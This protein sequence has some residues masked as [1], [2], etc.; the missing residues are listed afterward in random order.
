[1]KPSNASPHNP[2]NRFR[3]YKGGPQLLGP[4]ALGAPGCPRRGSLGGV[5]ERKPRWGRYSYD[6]ANGNS[7]KN[8]FK[9]WISGASPGLCWAGRGRRAEPMFTLLG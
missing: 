8:A 9:T 2:R 7:P 6:R 4:G 1:M 5:G 3:I